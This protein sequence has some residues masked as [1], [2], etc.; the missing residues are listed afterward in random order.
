MALG[1]VAILTAVLF[2]L[3]WETG[4]AH[5]SVVYLIRW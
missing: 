5:G 3:V 2:S 1:L 4:L